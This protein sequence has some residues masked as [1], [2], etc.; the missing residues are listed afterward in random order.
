MASVTASVSPTRA[1]IAGPATS[2]NVHASIDLPEGRSIVLPLGGQRDIHGLAGAGCRDRRAGQLSHRATGGR[3]CRL[4]ARTV[5][6]RRF[7]TEA[8][9]LEC[10]RARRVDEPD[11][12]EAD[13][14]G[15]GDR[16]GGECRTPRGTRARGTE[17]VGHDPRAGNCHHG[18]HRRHPADRGP[19]GHRED[20][21]GARRGGSAREGCRNYGIP[22]RVRPTWRRGIHQRVA[23]RSDVATLSGT[24]TTTFSCTKA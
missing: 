23:A 22:P 2:P 3:G 8:A 13:D 17:E 5:S 10:P 6:V 11:G 20:D 19:D 12:A 1:T 15:H 18:H 14:H 24:P 7:R 16:A 21:L 9:R 4:A